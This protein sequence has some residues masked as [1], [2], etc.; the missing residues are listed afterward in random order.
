[1][2]MERQVKNMRGNLVTRCAAVVI[3]AAW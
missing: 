2:P 3:I 1:M